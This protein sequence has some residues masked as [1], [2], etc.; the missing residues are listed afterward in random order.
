MSREMIRAFVAVPLPDTVRD[1]LHE[2]QQQLRHDLHVS[3]ARPQAIHLTLHFLGDVGPDQARSIGESLRAACASHAPFEMQT[4]GLGVFPHLGRPRVLWAGLEQAEPLIDL[5]QAIIVPIERCGVRIQRRSF[6]PHLTLA[7]IRSLLPRQSLSLLR[8][9]MGDASRE[10]GTFPVE[11]VRLYRS[12]L[13]PAGA[14]YT[15][16]ASAKLRA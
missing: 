8:H 13:H 10:F 2:Q 14:R 7:R 16:L 15:V 1:A 6:K 9:I 12:E 5:Q 3:W 11:E 4:R